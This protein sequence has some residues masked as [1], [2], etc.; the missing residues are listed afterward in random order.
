MS[1]SGTLLVGGGGGGSEITFN[2]DVGSATTIGQLLL[3]PGG[4][5]I[6]T[7]G[8]GNTLT[9]AVSGTTNNAVQIGN[10]SGSLTSVG[11]ATDG[12]LLIGATGL[13]LRS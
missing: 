12:Q 8:A 13:A 11:P 6:S 9:I 10:A 1:Q 2:A 7:T 4:A 3:V 5:N